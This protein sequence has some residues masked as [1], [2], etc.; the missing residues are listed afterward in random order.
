M[1]SSQV[2]LRCSS[3]RGVFVQLQA[4][5]GTI[6]SVLVCAEKWGGGRGGAFR[7]LLEALASSTT[8][9]SELNMRMHL[10]GRDGRCT[11]VQLC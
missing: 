1:S 5:V 7:S 3:P 6:V 4:W 8:E 2:A 11:D 9:L 10:D